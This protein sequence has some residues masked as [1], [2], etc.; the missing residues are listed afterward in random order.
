MEMVRF[1]GNY[2]NQLKI[3]EALNLFF[4]KKKKKKYLKNY[5]NYFLTFKKKKKIKI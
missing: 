1:E 3:I 2:H 4:L 5:I